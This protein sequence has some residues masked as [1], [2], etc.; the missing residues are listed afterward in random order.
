MKKKATNKNKN[1]LAMAINLVY[2]RLSNIFLYI[3]ELF[4]IQI[5]QIYGQLIRVHF[6]PHALAYAANKRTSKIIN[7]FINIDGKNIYFNL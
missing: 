7:N 2:E 4:P 6:Y 5:E 3:N 1:V